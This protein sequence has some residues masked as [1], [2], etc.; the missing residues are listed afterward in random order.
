MKSEKRHS[1][2]FIRH[3][4]LATCHSSLITCH[5]RPSAGA[6]LAIRAYHTRNNLPS[7]AIQVSAAPLLARFL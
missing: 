3:L 2:F 6:F 7:S 4:L 5:Y 1:S